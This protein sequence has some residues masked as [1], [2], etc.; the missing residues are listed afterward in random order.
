MLKYLTSFFCSEKSRPGE[1]DFEFDLIG[2]E[3]PLPRVRPP[4]IFNTKKSSAFNNSNIEEQ[5]LSVI[6]DDKETRDHQSAELLFDDFDDS[7]TTS[8]VNMGFSIEDVRKALATCNNDI[9]EALNFL[10]SSV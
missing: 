2:Q 4:T 8:L 1:N 9:N 7:R 3:S 6:S 5:L 10:L